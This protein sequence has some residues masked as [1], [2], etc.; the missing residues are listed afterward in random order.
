M[1]KT[2]QNPEE[3]KF[4]QLIVWPGTIMAEN[5][6][7]VT[8]SHIEK[9]ENYF[10]TEYDV[11]IKYDTTVITLPDT[12]ENNN[13]VEGTGGRPDISFYVHDDDVLKF[14]PIKIEIGARWYEDIHFNDGTG[15]YPKEFIEARPKTW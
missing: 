12:D 1:D 6:D 3:N 7:E 13:P 8:E 11:K 15:I 2:E 9:F 10:K 14:A 5:A 4:T